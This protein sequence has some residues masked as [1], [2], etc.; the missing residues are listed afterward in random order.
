MFFIISTQIRPS[1]RLKRWPCSRD[2]L[3]KRFKTYIRTLLD[4]PRV[5]DVN[6]YAQLLSF[7]NSINGAVRS[8]KNSGYE[9]ELDSSAILESI[10]DKL[11]DKVRSKWGKKLVKSGSEP[12]TLRDFASFLQVIVRAEMMVKS[13]TFNSAAASDD[14][15]T[16]EEEEVPN[17]ESTGGEDE[18]DSRKVNPGD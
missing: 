8:L 5:S 9:H 18:D 1:Q 13:S 17:E 10:L 6:Q 7:S 15:S 2:V 12:L 11:P 14:E 16:G 4:L 3:R